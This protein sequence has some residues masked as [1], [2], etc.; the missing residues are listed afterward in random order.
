[1]V[2]NVWK[3]VVHESSPASTRRPLASSLMIS[4]RAHKGRGG[5]INRVSAGHRGSMHPGST[6]PSLNHRSIDRSVDRPTTKG[7]V[8]ERVNPSIE[9]IDQMTDSVETGAQSTR[10]GWPMPR[11]RD[12]RPH[13]IQTLRLT[14]LTLRSSG[15]GVG[16]S[17]GGGAA[18]AGGG[19]V[20]SAMV[21]RAC[22]ADR[23]DS[24]GWVVR[25]EVR[26]LC[27]K[28]DG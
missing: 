8:N 10:D 24:V 25:H 5:K 6:H 1:M 3:S 23:I 9:S 20:D 13:H 11:S 21:L 15:R 27:S 14:G 16:R 17:G 22:G 7:P 4:C 28:Q 12:A 2:L 19:A 18:G 26:G